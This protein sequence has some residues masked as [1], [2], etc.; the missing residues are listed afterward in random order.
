VAAA[1]L[2]VGAAVG[3][4]AAGSV[5]GDIVIDANS[6]DLS[7]I[8]RVPDETWRTLSQ[9]RIYFGH[10][11]VG[12]NLL[13]GVAD[14]A[15]AKPQIR[16]EVRETSD[17]SK[18]DR[19]GLAH[20]AIGT[21]SDALGKIRDFVRRVEAAGPR[22]VDVAFMKFCYVDFTATTDVEAL[23]TAYH[24]AM[25]GLGQKMPS[26]RILHVTVPLTTPQAGW[27]A[28]VKR[29]IGKRPYGYDENRAR[30]RFNERLRAQYGKGDVVDLAAAEATLPD[31][32]LATVRVGSEPV[33]IL[34]P[35]Y[36]DDGGHLNEAGRRAG[37]R[38]LL[39]ALAHAVRRGPPD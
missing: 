14:I 12:S 6:L 10:Q 37:A 33:P 24:D 32:S 31:G 26:T 9:K 3:A 29:L 28:G 35:A 34:P 5:P 25:K 19:P 30:H 1:L 22:G 2:V 23:F 13:E 17:L 39:L 38:T 11:S 8:D 36:T 20:S 18:L 7:A 15:R 4:A 27:K 21:N 16:L